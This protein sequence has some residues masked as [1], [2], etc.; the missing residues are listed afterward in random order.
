MIK[1]YVT[2]IKLKKIKIED[3]PEKYRDKVQEEIGKEIGKE[4]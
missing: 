1:F 4:K 2:Q 3:V